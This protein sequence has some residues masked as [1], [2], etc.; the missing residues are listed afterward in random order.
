MPSEITFLEFVMPSSFS[1]YS[2]KYCSL[3]YECVFCKIHLHHVSMD[4]FVYYMIKKNVLR[5]EFV[6]A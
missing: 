6:Q 3:C 4:L 5:L 2:L 1:A